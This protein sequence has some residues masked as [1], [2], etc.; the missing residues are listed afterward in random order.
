MPGVGDS[1]AGG[2]AS[3][4]AASACTSRG[5]G[6]NATAV[7]RHADERLSA[8]RP[9]SGSESGEHDRRRRERGIETTRRADASAK[10][11]GA[12]V[13]E[14]TQH[15][16]HRSADPAR[17]A[18]VVTGLEQLVVS[19]SAIDLGV[20]TR[21]S[22]S[23]RTRSVSAA[24]RA[25]WLCAVSRIASANGCCAGSPRATRRAAANMNDEGTSAVGSKKIGGGAGNGS[26][27][28]S[29]RRESHMVQTGFPSG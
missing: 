13:A 26:T 8:G 7:K 5:S 15:L 20:T 18:R 10:R 22:A 11:R 17:A 9:R 23:V 12:Q 24:R 19:R 21:L 1:R 25:A 16:T 29:A 14:T 2:R 28:E 6:I 27:K 3:A 4:E